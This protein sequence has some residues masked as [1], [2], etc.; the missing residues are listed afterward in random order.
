MRKLRSPSWEERCFEESG[1]N[2]YSEGKDLMHM[3]AGKMDG[4]RYRTVFWFLRI[5]NT[6]WILRTSYK[7]TT[8]DPSVYC[9]NF[10]TFWTFRRI[11]PDSPRSEGESYN[12]SNSCSS[13]GIFLAIYWVNLPNHR[14]WIMVG[15]IAQIRRSLC[16]QAGA[17]VALSWQ[18]CGECTHRLQNRGRDFKE[19]EFSGCVLK[20]IHEVLKSKICDNSKRL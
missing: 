15:N 1:V 8:W 11:G 17:G 12:F 18:N 4:D 7:H 2:F 16:F 20:V 3:C 9:T 5:H 19:T 10:Q 6:F 14:R 13:R